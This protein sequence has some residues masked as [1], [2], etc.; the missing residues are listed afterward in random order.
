MQGDQ[1]GP[2]LFFQI[3]VL[4][5]GGQRAV[6]EERLEFFAFGGMGAQAVDDAL[7]ALTALLAFAV[8]FAGA[9]DPRQVFDSLDHSMQ[10]V[11]RIVL[12]QVDAVF[13]TGDQ[14]DERLDGMA[15]FG[16]DRVG[17]IRVA[18][19]LPDRLVV[20][21]APLG[22]EHGGRLADAAVGRVEDAQQRDVGV[23]RD[24]QLGVGQHV[25]HLAAVVEALGAD[26][27]IGDLAL[28]Q[29][30]FEFAA[31]AV[32]AEQHREILPLAAHGALAGHD[33]LGDEL[34]LLVV[35]G[36]GDNAHRI[37][38][39]ARR[40]QDFLAPAA[41][42][43][44]QAVGGVQHR[45]GRAVIL[46]QADDL[47]VGEKPLELEDVGHFGAAPAVDRLVVVADHADVIGRA[48]ELL[49]QPHLQRVGV[50]ELIDGDAREALA[51]DVAHVGVLAQ[52]PFA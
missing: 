26:H 9:F 52:H 46:L 40:A 41:V 39:L 29:R 33:F 5:L 36:H 48:H 23:G 24:Q 27:P 25:A 17:E 51:E 38:A 16:G 31:L 2:L 37:A 20:F 11:G 34:R 44:N 30:E 7:D 14:G 22:G 43:H 3:L 32:G 35:A 47:G 19:C 28:A 12:G 13:G 21:A 18:E 15:G 42:V 49:E 8:G 45:V 4:A 1:G 10:D 50:L 6:V